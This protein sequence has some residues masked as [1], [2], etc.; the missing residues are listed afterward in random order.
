MLQVSFLFNI[1]LFKLNKTNTKLSF[2]CWNKMRRKEYI[3]IQYFIFRK[4]TFLKICTYYIYIYIF[5]FF[6][7]YI[8]LT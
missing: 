4:L 2:V 1:S 3:I 5:F 8:K 7:V 6:L